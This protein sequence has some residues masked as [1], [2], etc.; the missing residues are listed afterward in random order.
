MLEAQQLKV[1]QFKGAWQTIEK[2]CAICPKI[3][4]LIYD[5][6]IIPPF[7]LYIS[8]SSH[9]NFVGQSDRVVTTEAFYSRDKRRRFM[10][11]RPLFLFMVHIR[12][13][14]ENVPHGPTNPF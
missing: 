4:G 13:T 8:S 2:H 3:T 7:C 6:F 5:F 11:K 9:A 12:N 1:N 10:L 14:S